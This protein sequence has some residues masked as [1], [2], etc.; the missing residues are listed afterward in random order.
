MDGTTVAE[1]VARDSSA[2]TSS[3]RSL[4][5][6]LLGISLF[7]AMGGTIYTLFRYMQPSDE[8]RGAG[9][10]AAETTI[11]LS[12]IP[13]GEA[14]TVRHLGEPHVVIRLPEAVHALNAICTH[15]GC[16]VYWDKEKK[17]LPCPCHAGFFDLNG[18][19]ISG[20]P[21]SPLPKATSKIVR[22]KIVVT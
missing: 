6:F 14:K 16:I 5:N 18:N 9:S 22:N 19:V 7:S 20:P 4:L 1:S 12:E 10:Q 21:P 8:V 15:L 2:K 17:I 13:V 11:P 3:R